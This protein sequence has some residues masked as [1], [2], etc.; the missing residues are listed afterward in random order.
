MRS[1]HALHYKL[2]GKF[3]NRFPL[4]CPRTATKSLQNRYEGPWVWLAYREARYLFSNHI[5]APCCLTF[6]RRVRSQTFEGGIGTP[7]F[8]AGEWVIGNQMDC[9]MSE[10]DAGA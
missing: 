3:S 8:L 1:V 4:R 10:R 7:R 5:A 2:V 9:V 6:V